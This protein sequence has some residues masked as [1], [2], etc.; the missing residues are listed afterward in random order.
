MV[1]GDRP[2][3]GRK[4]IVTED[5]DSKV[6]EKLA[7]LD[8]EEGGLPLLL[9]FYR[10]LLL[11]LSEARRQFEPGT[12][13]LKGLDAGT[14]RERL[15]QGNPLLSADD[16]G[17]DI[18]SLQPVF[19]RVREIFQG[20]AELFDGIPAGKAN[21]RPLT[22]GAVRA[23]F[24]GDSL[25]PD[26]LN[27]AE[28]ATVR[29]MVNLTLKPLLAACTEIL[30]PGIE[31]ERWRRR[32]CPICGGLPDFAYLD[33]ERGSRWLICSRCDHA[34]P[35]NR[36]QC[37]YCGTVDPSALAFFTDE[38]GLYRLHVCERCKC[39]LKTIDLRKTEDEVLPPLERLLTTDMDRQARE[40]GYR[41]P[42]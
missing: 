24:N 1:P 11:V 21:G 2:G 35:F 14:A 16:L 32:Q 26:I 25:P 39:Y 5:T 31:L 33:R 3:Q 28:E 12:P 27:G 7:E 8:K 41:P 38:K 10:D 37:P 22:E 17:S 20:Y 36:L 42:G 23:C 18:E 19:T 6:L 29:A 9:K 13:A 30:S 4:N 40:Q 34:W 15:K